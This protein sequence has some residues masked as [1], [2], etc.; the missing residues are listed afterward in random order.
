VN[1]VV[2]EQDLPP[3]EAPVTLDAEGG[4]LREWL[5]RV[6]AQ[7]GLA[8]KA[9]GNAVMI[10]SRERLQSQVSPRVGEIPP[11]M[12]ENLTT[13]ISV[14]FQRTWLPFVCE[15]L[16]PMMGS[17]VI[18]PEGDLDDYWENRV[19]LFFKGE[20]GEALDLICLLTGFVW[21][22]RGPVILIASRDR[23]ESMTSRLVGVMS[24]DMEGQLQKEIKIS[25]EWTYLP[26]VA[27]T[28]TLVVGSPVI[29]HRGDLEMSERAGPLRFKGDAQEAM[30]LICWIS[31][32][33]WR[34]DAGVIAIARGETLQTQVLRPL[35][36]AGI[37]EVLG[38][39]VQFD[40]DGLDLAQMCELLE[41]N[42]GMKCS[43]R[44]SDELEDFSYRW[45][46]HVD[47]TLEEALDSIAWTN[48]FVWA[49]EGDAVE[50]YKEKEL[51]WSDADWLGKLLKARPEIVGFTD[52][53]GQTPLHHACIIGDVEA[54]KLLLAAG[55]DVEARNRDGLTPLDI[56]RLAGNEDLMG[57]LSKHPAEKKQ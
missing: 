29:V 42:T 13:Q 57:L 17:P 55:A 56:A 41:E 47:G 33:K 4:T 9:E 7:A 43:V 20:A 22:A 44:E 45:A 19:T 31:E 46:L 38:Q 27:Q 1:I 48:G 30:D 54:A 12:E 6:C 36:P 39:E 25:F 18:F 32:M 24:P 51:F 34:A 16:A 21:R 3:D 52:A 5:D 11:E 37:R 35:V 49:A 2:F 53:F 28:L 23:L 26:D 8:W 50:F 15:V 14:D 10:G 40:F